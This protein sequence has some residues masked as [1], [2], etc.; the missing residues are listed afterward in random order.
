MSRIGS[1]C[2]VC[3]A[4][5]SN[6]GHLNSRKF[7][8]MVSGGEISFY[9]GGWSILWKKVCGYNDSICVE[10]PFAVELTTYVFVLRWIHQFCADNTRVKFSQLILHFVTTCPQQ[11]GETG[12]RSNDSYRYL[13][14]FKDHLSERTKGEHMYCFTKLSQT[15][16][17]PLVFKY[18]CLRQGVMNILFRLFK[19]TNLLDIREVYTYLRQGKR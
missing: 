15:W 3:R 6:K 8:C 19:G 12:T 1:L 2:P 4:N 18:T 5:H 7:D 10:N 14:Q 16:G 11:R 13:P 17:Q 9:W